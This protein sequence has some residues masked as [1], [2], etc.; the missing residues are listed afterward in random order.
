[1]LTLQTLSHFFE[2]NQLLAYLMI[3]LWVILE[4]EFIL[5]VTGILV[6][7]GVL[8]FTEA[9]LVGFLGAFTKTICWYYT[10]VL[11]FKKYPHSRFFRYLE[12]KVFSIL[13]NFKK[14]PFWSIFG[15]KFIYGINHFTMIFSGYLKVKFQKY[16]KAEMFSS[17][18]WVCGLLLL[19][20]FFSFTAL[21]ITQNVRNF[22]ILIL[23]FLLAFLFIEKLIVVLYEIW[24]GLYYGDNGNGNHNGDEKE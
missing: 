4:G 23:I 17:I 18:P 10:G 12:K 6:H 7:L 24:K 3:F 5:V 14:R 1:M 21:N 16:F 13:P 2:N 15:S 19:G 22:V 8:S 20:Y 9:F 11:I